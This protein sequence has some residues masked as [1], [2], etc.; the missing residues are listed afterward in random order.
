MFI[1]LSPL[2]NKQIDRPI[3]I[4]SPIDVVNKYLL[5]YLF[6]NGFGCKYKNCGRYYQRFTMTDNLDVDRQL[7]SLRSA[8]HDVDPVTSYFSFILWQTVAI[9]LSIYLRS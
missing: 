8:Y 1:R 4:A 5:I 6:F 2:L 9:F 3:A 7:K